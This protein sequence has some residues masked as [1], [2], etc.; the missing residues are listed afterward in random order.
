MIATPAQAVGCVGKACDDQGPKGNGCF[1]DRVNVAS[2]GGNDTRLF[3]SPACHAFWA[4]S[5]NGAAYWS[6]EV[7]LE[8]EEYVQKDSVTY[9]WVPRKRL[10]IKKPTMQSNPDPEWTNALGARTS[11]FRFRALWVDKSGGLGPVVTPWAFGG[12][13]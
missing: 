6:T 8:M 12:R 7:H 4:W 11:S 1:A 5:R 3:Y 13:R 2:G 10:T 9:V